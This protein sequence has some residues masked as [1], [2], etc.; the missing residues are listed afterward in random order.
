MT[1]TGNE[2]EPK[3]KAR[4]EA[5]WKAHKEA[6]AAHNDRARAEGKRQRE[7][8][9]RRESDQRKSV[10]RREDAEFARRLNA[11]PQG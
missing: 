10:E 11:R 8:R 7:E 1:D 5:A 2:A 3:P 6:I 4:G 9:E